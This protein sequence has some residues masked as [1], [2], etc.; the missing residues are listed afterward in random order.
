MLSREGNAE[1]IRAPAEKFPK[2]GNEKEVRKI[3]KNN[4]IKP[5]PG[6]R[7]GAT[8]KGPKNSKKRLK[9]SKKDQKIPCM[10]NQGARTPVPRVPTP[11]CRN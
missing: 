5:F 9:N 7:E 2:G 1:T 10:K 8:E 4:T 6:G 11:K 3:T